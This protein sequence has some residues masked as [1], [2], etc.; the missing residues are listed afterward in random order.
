MANARIGQLLKLVLR[1]VQSYSFQYISTIYQKPLLQ[2]LIFF[3]MIR[4]FFRFS[5]ILRHHQ[6]FSIGLPVENDI[7]PSCLKAVQICFFFS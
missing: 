7:Q 3:Q 1:R 6:N 2:M 4:H 5:M